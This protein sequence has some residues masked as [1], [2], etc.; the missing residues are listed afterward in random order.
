VI[1]FH[2]N[3]TGIN[4]KPLLILLH[5][6]M[7][8]IYEFDAVISFLYHDFYILKIDLPGH[9]KNQVIDNDNKF[10][11]MEET[12]KALV[13]FLDKIFDKLNL[14]NCYLIGY[15]MGGRLGLYLTLNYPQYFN[16]VILESASPGLRSE[17]E[18]LERQKRDGQIAR[19]LERCT[20]KND[21]LTFL[22]NWYG[23]L[24]F[25][26][27]K[28]HPDFQEVIDIRSA[29]DPK[30]LAKSLKFMGSGSQPSL[31]EKLKDNQ[32]PLLLLVG[33]Y[34]EKFT[35][36]NRKMASFCNYCDLKIIT[37]AGHNIHFEKRMAFVSVVKDFFLDN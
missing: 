26:D 20:D 12:A 23:Q 29:N 6:F 30:E 21:F 25:G 36:I 35:E 34:D 31:W 14:N 9:G 10:Y 13:K 3:F 4:Q 27:I 16:K 37:Q 1:N 28:N 7:G 19:K 2:Y 32:V 8:N 11:G 18:R 22:D 33:E 17:A 15:S 24:V 5:G